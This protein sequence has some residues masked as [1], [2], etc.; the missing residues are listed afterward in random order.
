[1][2]WKIFV[3]VYKITGEE[4]LTKDLWTNILKKDADRDL[5]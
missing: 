2:G 5:V 4:K 3:G 1:M